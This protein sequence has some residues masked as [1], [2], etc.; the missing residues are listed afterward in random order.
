MM[1]DGDGDAF[2]DV[3][4]QVLLSVVLGRV[5]MSSTELVWKC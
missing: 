2:G 4:P 5:L 3:T 1:S